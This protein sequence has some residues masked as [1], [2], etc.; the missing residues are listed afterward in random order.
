MWPIS[1]NVSNLVQIDQEL[2]EICL[3]CIFQDGGRRHLEF[4]KSVIF[5]PR[6]HLCGRYLSTYQIWCRLI[7]NWPRYALLCIFQDG[8]RRHLGFPKNVIFN[9]LMTLMWPISITV[10][11]LGQI[12][13]ELAE[14]HPFV[15]FPR[16]RPQPSWICYSSILDHPRCPSCWVLCYLPMAWWSTWIYPRYCDLPFHDLGWKMPIPA[17]F[18]GLGDFDPLKLWHHHSNPKGM[19]FPWNHAFWH[20]ARENRFSG[21]TCRLV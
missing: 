19:Q 21:L 17:N 10:S 15:Y 7:K 3:L 2:D 11:N 6:W 13:Q 18:G 5:N 12:D 1:I 9:P 20:I 16:R 14:I 8:V 4:P